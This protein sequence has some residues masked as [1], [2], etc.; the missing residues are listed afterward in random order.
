MIHGSQTVLPGRLLAAGAVCATADPDWNYLA[1]R[2]PGSAES[3]SLSGVSEWPRVLAARAAKKGCCRIGCILFSGSGTGLERV[4]LCEALLLLV[5][6][7]G[8][9]ALVEGGLR[10]LAVGGCF[11]GCGLRSWSDVVD[12]VGSRRG[13]LDLRE[14][15]RVDRADGLQAAVVVLRGLLRGRCRGGAAPGVRISTPMEFPAG[16]SALAARFR[17][18]WSRRLTMR[19]PSP[20][21]RDILKLQGGGRRLPAR[22]EPPLPRLERLRPAW[23]PADAVVPG[24]VARAGV[25]GAVEVGDDLSW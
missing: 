9:V 20:G 11:L 8:L 18:R 23:M 21:R 13:L 3:V 15:S 25:H 14:G 2:L 7:G 19:R 16:G 10:L 24:A 1:D 22:F 17:G 12:R 4:D 5:L 6:A